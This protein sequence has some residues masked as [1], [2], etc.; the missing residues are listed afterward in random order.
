[1]PAATI[2]PSIEKAIENGLEYWADETT[3]D[4]SNTELDD[5]TDNNDTPNNNDNECKAP[6]CYPMTDGDGNNND[7]NDK[8]QTNSR[9]NDPCDYYGLDVCDKNKNGC[10]NK[11]FDCLTALRA[12][13]LEMI[14]TKV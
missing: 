3:L 8:S 14:K 9:D 5:N 10:D 4:K 11:N 2:V 6:N 1:M 12:C 13:V 7:N